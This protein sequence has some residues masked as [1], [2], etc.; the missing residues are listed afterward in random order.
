MLP[1]LALVAAACGE[2]NPVD[3]ETG[4]TGASEDSSSSDPTVA[5]TTAP[6]D[7]SGSTTGEPTATD[8][9]TGVDSSSSTGNVAG[10]G[11]GT[12]EDGEECDDGNELD[13]DE[14]SATCTIPYEVVWT[15]SHDGSASNN[16]FVA[17]VAVDGAGNIY[18]V[19]RERATDEGF[20]LWLRQYDAE[21][22]EVWTVSYNAP[23]GGDEE[24]AALALLD[25][26]DIIIAGTVETE[27]SGDDIFIARVDGTT[28]EF[29]WEVVQDGP[30]MG[31]GEP[32]DADS[33]S[34]VVVDADG[35]L[36]VVGSFRIGTQDW[37]MWIGKYDADGVELWQSGHTGAEGGADFGRSVV[38]DGEG[39][40]WMFG[41]EEG[42]DGAFATA[43]GFDTDGTPLVDDIQVFDFRAADLT[44]DVDGNFVA[45]GTA[46]PGATFDDFVVRKYDPTW[47]ETWAIVTD[48]D[49]SDDLASGMSVG[50]TGTIYVA[51]TTRVTATNYDAALRVYDTDGNGLWGAIYGNEKLGDQFNYAVEHPD[52]DVVAGGFESVFGEQTNGLVMKYR[53]L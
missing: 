52:G 38:V 22:A 33:A 14:C 7:S 20:N 16:D 8:P 26:G 6:A 2:D 37:D 35:N 34:D 1:S 23:F 31:K 12:L 5:P 36:Y 47:T 17:E 45:A 11:D 30:G 27:T 51:G 42:A 24:G 40:A 53:A 18:V 50:P 9:T 48:I 13:G 10:C 41:N 49:G 19:G 44:I 29:E 21:G 25:D 46:A 39:T 15:E 28:Q 43:I 3:A 4:P 32:D